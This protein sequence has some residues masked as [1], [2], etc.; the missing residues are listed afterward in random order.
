M[1]KSFLARAISVGG[2]LSVAMGLFLAVGCSDDDNN[3]NGASSE[4]ITAAIASDTNF[5][6]LDSALQVSGL[7][8]SLSNNGPYTL[9]APT[10]SAFEALPDAVLDSLFA[11]PQDSLRR[12]LQYHVVQGEL[13]SSNLVSG[14]VVALSGD[15]LDVVVQG[16]QVR[17]NDAEVIEPDFVVE[18]GVV[19][20]INEVLI[21][22]PVSDTVQ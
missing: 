1:R 9:F 18:N 13:V 16:S 10:D 17:V 5:T 11:H 3:V 14:S 20:V 15:T 19:H 8:Q 21:P 2:A 22:P 12:V 6:I 4:G 7:A